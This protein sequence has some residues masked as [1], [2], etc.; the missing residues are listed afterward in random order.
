MIGNR[1]KRFQLFFAVENGR[2]NDLGIL[3]GTK[4]IGAAKLKQN[5]QIVIDPRTSL[6]HLRLI[7][8][9]AVLL[10]VPAAWLVSRTTPLIFLV[11][12]P[13]LGCR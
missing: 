4:E 6:L 2:G 13:I 5:N 7:I 11:V 12:P 3:R 8:V 1:T 9:A 10:L